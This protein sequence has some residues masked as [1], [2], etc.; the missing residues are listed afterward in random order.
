MKTYVRTPA[1]H[2]HRKCYVKTGF[3]G[4]PLLACKRYYRG[5]ASKRDPSYSRGNSSG[6]RRTPSN[7]LKLSHLL[8]FN[9]RKSVDRYEFTSLQ[10]WLEQCWQYRVIVDSTHKRLRLISVVTVE[11]GYQYI[12]S[13]AIL[14]EA[15]A[16]TCSNRHWKRKY[17]PHCRETVSKSTYY[18]HK[19]RYI[20]E[21]L[22]AK[23]LS[24]R[25][26]I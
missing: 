3:H 13:K 16:E 10:L 25:M 4:I 14:M 8:S 18:S 9:F 24:Y 11:A 12:Y 26:L 17:C 15:E 20:Y 2:T 19:A 21:L 23:L 6:R 5:V 22:F 1:T 7:H